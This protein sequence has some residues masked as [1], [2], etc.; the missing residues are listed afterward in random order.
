ME[1]CPTCSTPL[2]HDGK[3]VSCAAAADG[4]VLLTR[5]DYASVREMMTLLEEDGLSPQMERVPPAHEQEQRQP[6]WNLYV[7]GEEAERAHQVLGGDW[8]SLL[9]NDAAIEAARRGS[10]GVDLDAGVEITC[11]AC[12]HAFVPTG[13]EVECPECGLGLGAPG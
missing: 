1:R 12:G 2:D 6:V 8:R 9:E 10:Q 11:P 5:F 4:L 7:P 13:G 3:C